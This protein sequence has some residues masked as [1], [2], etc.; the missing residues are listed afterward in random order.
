MTGIASCTSLRLPVEAACSA[1]TTGS[2]AGVLAFVLALVTVSATADGCCRQTVSYQRLPSHVDRP[3]HL[4]R[5]LAARD[6]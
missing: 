6:S 4:F 5:E 2:G 1:R 3:T